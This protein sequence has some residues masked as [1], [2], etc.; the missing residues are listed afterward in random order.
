MN[1]IGH[2]EGIYRIRSAFL[3]WVC[4]WRCHWIANR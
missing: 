4:P 2:M 1:I 3:P